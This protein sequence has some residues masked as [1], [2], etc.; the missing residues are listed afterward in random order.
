[1]TATA[2]TRNQMLIQRGGEV[3]QEEMEQ[4]LQQQEKNLDQQD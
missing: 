2:A 3:D 1:M 4:G